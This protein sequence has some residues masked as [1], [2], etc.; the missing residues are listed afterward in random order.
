MNM[1]ELVQLKNFPAMMLLQA[2]FATASSYYQSLAETQFMHLITQR[3]DAVDSEEDCRAKY[4]SR[5]LFCKLA[6]ESRLRNNTMPDDVSSKLFCDDLRPTNILLNA[7]IKIVAVID[8]EFTYT[9]PAE[10]A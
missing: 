3:N 8:W 4:I 9:A 2:P 10:F 5:K 1:N 6:G 7:D